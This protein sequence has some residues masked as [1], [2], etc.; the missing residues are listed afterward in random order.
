MEEKIYINLKNK[1]IGGV[2]TAGRFKAQI[3]K[4][5]QEIEND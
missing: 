1:S 3:E 4:L 2:T 5:K